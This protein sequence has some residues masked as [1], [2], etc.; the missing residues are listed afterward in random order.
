MLQHGVVDACGLRHVSCVQEA[1]VFLAE[2]DEPE[3]YHG[4]ENSSSSSES[5]SAAVPAADPNPA[6]AFGSDP[7]E[8][9]AP[10]DKAVV[11][12]KL[13]WQVFVKPH[14]TGRDQ[15]TF[16]MLDAMSA[17]DGRNRLVF[18]D[19][20]YPYNRNLKADYKA[21]LVVMDYKTRYAQV[22]PLRSKEQTMEAFGVVAMRSG[23]HKLPHG[24]H[25]VSD[26]EPKLVQQ[27]AAA[28]QRLGLM[29]STSVPNRPNTNPAGSNL[30]RSLRRLVDCALVDGSRWG[31]VINGTFEA[32]AWEFAV[33]THNALANRSDPLNRSPHELN[34]GVPPTFQQCAFGTPGYMHL[35]SNGRRAHIARCGLAG[36][37]RAER[38]LY[39]GER[40][41]HHR[42]LTERGT[43][44]C[45]PMFVD[46]EGIL[47][48]F[49][50]TVPVEQPVLAR[51][52]GSEDDDSSGPVPAVPS[53]AAVRQATGVLLTSADGSLR[54][55][56]GKKS[57]SKD[58][59]QHRCQAVVGLTVEQ[60]LQQ[61]FPNAAG[62][63]TRFRRSDLDY[64]IK[65]GRLQ[66]EVIESQQA[67]GVS[68]QDAEC[69]HNAAMMMLAEA[70]PSEVYNMSAAEKA[71]YYAFLSGVVAQKGL[72]WKRFLEPTSEH[73]QDAI[74]AYNK[75]LQSIISMGVM[76]EL[77]PGT[78]RYAEALTSEATTLCRVL[79]DR[80]RDGTLK[81]R[82]V[83][84]GDLENTLLTDGADFNYYAGTAAS[85]SVR[86]ALL[87]SGR[88]V[89]STGE[90]SAEKL[91][92]STDDVTS[93][94]CQSH[95]YN[96]GIDRFLKLNSPLDGVWRYFDQHKPLYGAC[97]APV[98][99]QDTF[100]EWITSSVSAGGP[101]FVRSMNAG[102][103]YYQPPRPERKEL[104][105]VLY[106]DDIMLIGRKSDQLSFYAQL[107]ARFQCKPVQ[108]LEPGKP[109]DYL[110]LTIHEDAE[111]TWIC[112]EAYIKNMCV[113]LNMENCVPM[114][115]P[116]SGSMTDQRELCADRKVWFA[117]AL[118]M[119]LWL[120]KCARPDIG[121]AASRIAQHAAAPTN[122]AYEA[123]VKL[124]RYCASTPKLA[125]RQDL[126]AHVGWQLF[127][128]SDM[129]G[130]AEPGNK[131]RSQ[132]GYVAMLGSAPITW[133]S[134]VSSVQFGPAALPAGFL[135]EHPPVT[136]H[137]D[138][139]G[140]HVATSSAEA[141]TY[142]CALFANE[143]LALS[144]IAEEAGM[145]FP[146]PAVI[147]VD[148]M[149]AIA[150]S[151]QAQ[152]SGRSK[153]RHV[154]C[155]QQWLQVLRD[156]NIVKCVHVSSEFNKA[157]IFTKALDTETFVRLRDTMLFHCPH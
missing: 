144:Y 85:A 110:G 126:N 70:E 132:L 25:V 37:H 155:R 113:I 97:S 142:A 42:G 114:A 150:F 129:A 69:L 43:S 88:H 156:S 90:T 10:V 12:P 152:F 59:I 18:C 40:D 74:N 36:A 138:I 124:V 149:A 118:G 50:E 81:A 127:S 122:G 103:I 108:W 21:F 112:M 139:K 16:A 79:L 137:R 106:V 30:V 54:V 60:A 41:G 71:E 107:N 140:E 121:Y 117:T 49:P 7:G 91:V 104:L 136:A 133:S 115:V 92:V 48:V 5:D 116:F 76:D 141:E 20:V 63:M 87:Q 27:I 135:S 6:A 34:F 101:G 4:D 146:K 15:P 131:R 11:F 123:L 61:S 93:A 19:Y 56:A 143:V 65:C 151:K 73:R 153:L 86:L 77:Q 35:T 31:S 14:A 62:A 83:V 72:S 75:E 100:A 33:H 148:N 134:K 80:K 24:V 67:G 3:E 119:V 29:H 44:R 109:I 125:I 8:P 130:N 51:G 98:R 68:V 53:G 95:R 57:S 111:F 32:I 52:M 128:D 22:Q 39:I 89:L 17:E 66:I 120:N 58:Y 96:D 84:R 46:L 105:L 38:V 55:V 28:C 82:I 2:L 23:W 154:D 147:Q 99:W 1:S 78:A 102:S 47:G 145:S 9:E 64:D 45:G 157:D 94:F 26:G 13:P